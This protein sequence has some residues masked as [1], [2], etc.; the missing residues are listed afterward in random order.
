M[1][2]SHIEDRLLRGETAVICYWHR[3]QLFCWRY[4]RQLID[5][6]ARI[7]WLISASV[8]GHGPSEIARRMGGGIV[9]RGSTTSG[10]TDA[11]RTMCKSIARDHV[12]PAT[13]PDGPSGPRSMFKPGIVKL[14]QLSGAP[15][16]PLSYCAERCVGVAHLGSVRH[17]E[18]LLQ[19]RG[20]RRRAGACAATP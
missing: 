19:D 16:I 17:S 11:L 2:A 8:D 18:A 10:G 12:S 9:F 15:L 14:A 20:F 5:R 4:L 7:G 3:H 1:A 13:T 6:G